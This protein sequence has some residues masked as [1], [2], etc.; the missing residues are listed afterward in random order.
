[1][2]NPKAPIYWHQGLFLQPEHFQQANL[3]TESLLTPFQNYLRPYFW[4]ACNLDIDTGALKQYSFSLNEGEFLF[5]DG[6]W[7]ALKHNAILKPRSFKGVWE[8]FHEPFVIYV[9]IKNLNLQGEELEVQDNTESG[10]NKSRFKINLDDNEVTDLYNRKHKAP[11][12]KL[13]YILQFIWEKE[14]EFYPEYEIIPVARVEFNGQEVICSKEF[15]PAVV[16][17]KYSPHLLSY[18]KNMRDALYARSLNLSAVKPHSQTYRSAD[19][20]K[21]LMALR[22]LN[23]YIPLLNH[24]YETPEISPW[25]LYGIFRQLLGELSFLSGT[26]DVLGRNSDGDFLVPPYDHSNLVYC[27]GQITIFINN[28]LD[29][30]LNTLETVI[31]LKQYGSYYKA[32]LP[33]ELLKDSNRFYLGFKLNQMNT[34]L[35]P[36]IISTMKIGSN[37]NVENLIKRA[38]SGVPLEPQDETP[39]G[40]SSKENVNYFRLDNMH[41]SWESIKDN[42]NI[43]LFS[44]ED[45]NGIEIDLF[46]LKGREMLT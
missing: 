15:I 38:L 21:Y 23:H 37:E 27:F 16:N 45:T 12:S 7:A 13:N 32:D 26:I 31:H 42:E 10:I 35:S 11:V 3:Y 30:L 29:E 9:G 33:T 39:L 4:G 8:K 43:C 44:L 22:V 40:I 24:Y 46:V 1:M 2:I 25:E 41:I 18:L 5:K 17:I 36:T 14:I 6:T 28:V 34:E 20:L 19:A